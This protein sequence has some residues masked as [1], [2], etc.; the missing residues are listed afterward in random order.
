MASD[1]LDLRAAKDPNRKTE[2]NIAASGNSCI[3]GD[4]WSVVEVEDVVVEL[5]GVMAAEAL[6][7]PLMSL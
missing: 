1:F 2:D 6:T 3:V 5:V 7:V 4:V